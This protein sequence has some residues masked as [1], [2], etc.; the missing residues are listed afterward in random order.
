MGGFGSGRWMFH[1]RKTTVEK[2][3][4]ISI[5]Q[6]HARC[7]DRCVSG[8]ISW[9]NERTGEELSSIAYV[10]LPPD[11]TEPMILLSYKVDGGTVQEPITLQRTIP[12]FGGARWWFT[13]PLC[14][15]RMGILYIAPGETF[16]AC[17]KCH[18]LA[19][20]RSGK[21]TKS[22]IFDWASDKL[23]KGVI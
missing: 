19:Y 22:S 15:R 20:R 2:C 23:K 9:V 8:Q 16:F 21:Y 11:Q 7:M 17:R 10:Y 3:L 12:H 14:K 4:S 13:C 6:F 1:R 18:N 5:S